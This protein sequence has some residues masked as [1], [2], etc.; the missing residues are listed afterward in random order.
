VAPTIS[1][2]VYVPEPPVVSE[3]K[4]KDVPEKEVTT[5]SIKVPDDPGIVTLTR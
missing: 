5:P 1:Q 3:V 4:A 2:E